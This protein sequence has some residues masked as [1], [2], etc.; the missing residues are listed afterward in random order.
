MRDDAGHAFGDAVGGDHVKAFGVARLEEEVHVTDGLAELRPRLP[1]VFD[2]LH[3][4]EAAHHLA[5]GIEYG[6]RSFVAAGGDPEFE[7]GAAA[8]G[9]FERGSGGGQEVLERAGGS[10]GSHAE[11]AALVRLARRIG[12]VQMIHVR[13][14]EAGRGVDGFDPAGQAVAVGRDAEVPC[15][16]AE[17]E[18][19]ADETQ[20]VGVGL[21]EAEI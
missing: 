6:T 19:F 14:A 18:T 12:L 17:F 4:G 2:E 3:M 11:R 9:D 1:S 20:G 8:V 13:Q 21:E 10:E 15:G 7:I 5:N 16:A